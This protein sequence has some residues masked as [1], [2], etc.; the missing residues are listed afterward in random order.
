MTPVV[1]P[2][3]LPTDPLLLPLEQPPPP[4]PPADRDDPASSPNASRS[5]RRKTSRLPV[6]SPTPSTSRLNGGAPPDAT[7]TAS[8]TNN[9]NHSTG[10]PPSQV[11]ASALHYPGSPSRIRGNTPVSFANRLVSS[12]SSSSSSSTSSSSSSISSSPPAHHWAPVSTLGTPIFP[13]ASVSQSPSPLTRPSP[14][15]NIPYVADRTIRRIGRRKSETSLGSKVS[16]VSALSRHSSRSNCLACQLKAERIRALQESN[17][18]RLKRLGQPG[19][20]PSSTRSSFT[21]PLWRPVGQATMRAAHTWS[22]SSS[23]DSE[24][25]R[26]R[27]LHRS[28]SHHFLTDENGTTST[29]NAAT[30]PPGPQVPMPPSASGGRIPRLSTNPKRSSWLQAQGSVSAPTSPRPSPKPDSSAIP[31]ARQRLPSSLNANGSSSRLPKS[32]SAPSVSAAGGPSPPASPAASSSRSSVQRSRLPPATSAVKTK[33][34]PDEPSASTSTAA[35]RSRIARSVSSRLSSQKAE[36]S[37]PAEPAQR[38][39]I[40][41]G[42]VVTVHEK[43]DAVEEAGIPMDDDGE[44]SNGKK[45]KSKKATKID[46]D[47]AEGAEHPGDVDADDEEDVKSDVA[48]VD[49]GT[50]DADASG[51]SADT[52]TPR[53]G[54]APQEADEQV[55][56]VRPVEETVVEPPAAV[57]DE[58]EKVADAEAVASDVVEILEGGDTAVS[59]NVEVTAG[60]PEEAT[61]D[62]P[63]EAPEASPGSQEKVEEDP[64]AQAA[65]ETDLANSV[66]KDSVTEE[67]VVGEEDAQPAAPVT[68]TV[69]AAPTPSISATPLLAATSPAVPMST[70]QFSD[71]ASIVSDWADTASM[72]SYND[73]LGDTPR[74]RHFKIAPARRRLKIDMH[75]LTGLA[76]LISARMA[77]C[78]SAHDGMLGAGSAREIVVLGRGIATS[79]FPVAQA[80]ADKRLAQQLRASL[81]VCETVAMQMRAIV[82]MKAGEATSAAGVVDKEGLV[83]ASARNVVEAAQ[84]ALKDLEAAQLMLLEGD[85][86]TATTAGAG[87]TAEAAAATNGSVTPA[88][89]GSTASVTWTATVKVIDD[90]VGEI[91]EVE[92]A[93]EDG[94]VP[95]PVRKN[96]GTEEALKAAIAA[97]AAAATRR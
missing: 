8:T 97:G 60:Q 74:G 89:S 37:A 80:C 96:T 88:V 65:E 49:V 1:D 34:K 59:A 5:L 2:S 64:A 31:T 77:D 26:Q 11:P 93:R 27:I 46:S 57:A 92:L 25:P 32:T 61:K 33:E 40:R 85:A 81:S 10:A 82:K 79:W 18:Y 76:R 4:A 70:P 6:T 44:I 39:T 54:V 21:Q 72:V 17:P 9:N 15:R 13:N 36:T 69:S 48:V 29:N 73:D 22:S 56:V 86:A 14:F 16:D 91:G 30:S 35:P 47:D 50:P 68:E 95:K 66:S 83:L 52:E 62:E 90:E 53:N 84:E 45:R 75:D 43:S 23:S 28:H 12:T 67:T 38:V 58:S 94:G 51:D 3:M 55:E 87:T 78:K 7:E 41:G 19:S 71:T 42:G 20:S 63:T 24:V